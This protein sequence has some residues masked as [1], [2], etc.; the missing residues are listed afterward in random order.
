MKYPVR[1]KTVAMPRMAVPT[2]PAIPRTVPKE[3]PNR[4]GRPWRKAWAFAMP[5]VRCRKL[6]THPPC[7]CTRER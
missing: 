4:S 1:T 2:L 6:P 5:C 3:L 7:A